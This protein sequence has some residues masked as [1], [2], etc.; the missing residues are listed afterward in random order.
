MTTVQTYIDQH[1]AIGDKSVVAS[2]SPTSIVPTG[3]VTVAAI[4]LAFAQAQAAAAWTAYVVSTDIGGVIELAVLEQILMDAGAI[5]VGLP[6]GPNVLKINGT[7]ANFA[8]GSTSVGTPADITTNI[9]W[10]GV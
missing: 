10:H 6:A 3:D 4:N 1:D 5:D 7:A 2:A 9:T 8:L